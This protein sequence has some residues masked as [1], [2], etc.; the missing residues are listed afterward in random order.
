MQIKEVEYFRAR[1]QVSQPIADSTHS[2]SEIAFFIT[3]I[4]LENGVTGE[5]NLLAFHYSPRAIAGALQDIAP[6]AKEFKVWETGRFLQQAMA[7][8]EYFGNVGLNKWAAGAINVAMWDAWGK[9]LGQ[10]VWKML[11]SYRDSVP[12]YGSGGVAELLD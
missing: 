1:S 7:A 2:I 8:S 3:R 6:L 10:P 11:G 9:T 5:S 4:H 12:V